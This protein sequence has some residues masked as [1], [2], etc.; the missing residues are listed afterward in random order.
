MCGTSTGSRVTLLRGLTPEDWEK[1]TIAG[2]WIV[3]DV[4][5]HI[6]DLRHRDEVEAPITDWLLEAYD[7]AAAATSRT[8]ANTSGRRP[9]PRRAE[10]A[11]AARRPRR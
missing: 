2:S 5:A 3:R 11:P 6:V 10:R 8:A 7:A 9:A 1:P 4:V